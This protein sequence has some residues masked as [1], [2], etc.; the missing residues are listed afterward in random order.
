MLDFFHVYM[1][2]LGQID[3]DQIC[4]NRYMMLYSSKPQ[5]RES[6]L[7]CSGSMD[8]V[9]KTEHFLPETNN[10]PTLS[11]PHSGFCPLNGAS[12]GPSLAA[13]PFSAEA[14]FPY[15]VCNI[16]YFLLSCKIRLLHIGWKKKKVVNFCTTFKMN[17]QIMKKWV[18]P[19]RT[20]PCL[21][22]P[23]KM[24]LEKPCGPMDSS[25][26][27]ICIFVFLRFF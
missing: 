24:H 18:S 13:L 19:I 15:I 14:A 17:L 23:K 20:H 16:S 12:I 5:H 1:Y 11:I 2:F 3:R 21:L 10:H 26:Y 4:C 6:G 25:F 8:D 22:L 7:M 9:D 27:A